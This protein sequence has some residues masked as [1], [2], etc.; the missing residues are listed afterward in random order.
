MTLLDALAGFG[1][2]VGRTA[3]NVVFGGIGQA[4][5]RSIRDRNARDRASDLIEA[6]DLSGAQAVID[7]RVAQR[8]PQAFLAA[9][10]D[11]E[12]QREAEEQQR[13]AAQFQVIRNIAFRGDQIADPRER[14]QY[15]QDMGS[16]LV[17]AGEIGEED[18][19]L[20]A[21]AAQTTGGFGALVNSAITPQQQITNQQA[22]ARIDETG[23]SNRA[24]EGLRGRE[25]QL[26]QDRFSL[27][28]QQ[29]R[30]PQGAPAA[31]EAAAAAAPTYDFDVIN[32]ATGFFDQLAGGARRLA[33][34]DALA[35]EVGEK[36]QRANQIM[37]DLVNDLRVAQRI[38]SGRASNYE[39]ALQKGILPRFGFGSG[40]DQLATSL[41]T[42]RDQLQGDIADN[43]ALLSNPG[44]TSGDRSE[45]IQKIKIQRSAVQ[46]IGAIL[47][48]RASALASEG[49]A[50]PT[51]QAAGGRT[52][53]PPAAVERLRQEPHLAE[54]FNMKYGPGAAEQ[55]LNG[56]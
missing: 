51:P 9:Q 47:Q 56:R 54:Q 50:A 12:M 37:N 3:D 42:T 22:Q 13:Q 52:A 8:N 20:L 28:Q 49:N 55:V 10:R 41:A 17:A 34:V 1:E 35:P 6:G 15:A 32:Y 46:R 5:A 14:M 38:N 33:V 39:L 45:L 29:A 4:T 24:S 43:E 44:L 11:V 18:L 53:P 25:A 31:G 36:A 16:L 23:R 2:T 26:A 40:E 30:P 48:S 21:Q 19:P 27:E 7:Q